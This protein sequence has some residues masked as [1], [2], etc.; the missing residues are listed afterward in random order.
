M[1]PEEVKRLAEQTY[2]KVPANPEVDVRQRARRSRRHRRRARLELKDPRAGNASFHRY[3][4]AP[5][6]T[7]AKAGRS[8]SA[9]PADEDPGRRRH[10]PPLSQAR[11]RGQ[12]RRHVGRRL[13]R[14]GS[15]RRRDL[16]LRGRRQ[17]QRRSTRSQPRSIAC[18]TRSARTAS[19]APSWSAPRKR[20]SPTSS[21][22]ATTRRAWP[23][24]TAG[25]SPS[26]ARLADIENWPQAIA[27]VTPEDIKRVAEHL[28]RP[29]RLGHGLAAAG[30]AR[31]QR[32]P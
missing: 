27:K 2:G 31:R 4:V 5:S 32:R 22:R 17:R 14:L 3:Y 12:D 28:S 19:P 23:A 7:T 25:A 21:T 16:A 8:R 29:A 13:L 24:A 18:S 1:T 10:Q 15:R 6:Y 26:A 9:R 20:S 11:R 30:R